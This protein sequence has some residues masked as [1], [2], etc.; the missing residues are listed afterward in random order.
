MLKDAAISLSLANLCFVKVWSK[1]LSS[2]NSYF[3]EFLVVYASII[4]DV[5][6][7]ALLIWVAITIARRSR[8]ASMMTFARYAFLIALITI[9]NGI[10]GLVVTFLPFNLTVL[11]G[12]RGVLVAGLILTIL[13]AYTLVQ[14]RKFFIRT[15]PRLILVLLPFV[16]L[17]FSQSV[18]RLSASTTVF[19]AGASRKELRN[20]VA[21]RVPTNGRVVWL[22]FDEMDQRMSF[23]ERPTSVHLPELDRL[24]SQSLYATKAYPPAPL[25]YMSMPALISGKLVAKV[26]PVNSHELMLNY[27]GEEEAVAWSSQPNIFSDARASGF[28]TGLVGWCHPYCDVIGGD[29]SSCVVVKEKGNNEISLRSSMFAQAQGLISTVPLLQ[30]AVLPLIQRVGVINQ[31]V[32]YGEREKYIFRYQHVLKGALKAVTDP[33]LDLVLIH[34]PAP[35][36]PGIYNRESHDFSMNGDRGYLDNLEL[37]DRTLG[38]LRN[39]MEKAG[40]WENT[41]VLISADHWWRTE[42]WSRGP[43]WTGE[44][45]DASGTKMDHRIPFILKMAGRSEAVNYD[46]AFNTVLTHDLLLAILRGDVSD[47]QSVAKWLDVH[48]SIGDSPFNRDDLL[49]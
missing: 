33:D 5:L 4:L 45:A 18:W 47:Q 36:P 8:F 3:G 6:L 39:A 25:T 42:M 1:L 2:N 19:A 48:R 34:C 43:F 20:T 15:A 29:L 49:P 37:A 24:R 28:K 30:Q 10:L 27:D 22:I 32:T 9:L 26:T 17:T 40:T 12:R 21:R 13:T 35:H 38:D 11:M 16:L 41:T 31:I 46:S 44:D 14:W 7:L 23:S